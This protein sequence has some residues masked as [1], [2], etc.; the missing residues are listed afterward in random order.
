MELLHVETPL[1]YHPPQL[2]AE[3]ETELTGLNSGGGIDYVIDIKARIWQSRPFI[4]THTTDISLGCSTTFS[5]LWSPEVRMGYMSWMAVITMVG[6]AVMP[7][8]I[9]TIFEGWPLAEIKSLELGEYIILA[10]STGFTTSLRKTNKYS[11][12]LILATPFRNLASLLQYRVFQVEQNLQAAQT[13]GAN[14]IMFQVL[15][16]R[17][18]LN[19]LFN[20]LLEFGPPQRSSIFESSGTPSPDGWAEEIHAKKNKIIKFDIG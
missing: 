6:G 15:H 7:F 14:Y 11:Q 5:C 20:I 1:V 19:E 12:S 3:S 8:F 9:G 17:P 16:S 18:E 4:R 10:W 2:Q 13:G